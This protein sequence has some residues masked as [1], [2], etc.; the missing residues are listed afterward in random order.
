MGGTFNSYFS[1][2]T[3]LM[4][5]LFGGHLMESHSLV[6]VESHSFM[7]EGLVYIPIGAKQDP[8]KHRL[9][10]ALRM[11]HLGLTLD[12]QWRKDLTL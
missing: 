9:L 1:F 3:V 8:C 4:Y 5:F 12:L 11:P 2:S 10:T 6:C 7:Q